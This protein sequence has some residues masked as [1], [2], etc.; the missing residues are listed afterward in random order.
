[1]L[2]LLLELVLLCFAGCGRRRSGQ[3]QAVQICV[4]SDVQV[5]LAE[6]LELRL[7]RKLVRAEL[8]LLLLL[9]HHRLLL[10]AV[11]CAGRV[12][13]RVRNE[14][15]HSAAAARRV[16]QLVLA[17]TNLQVVQLLLL[18]LQVAH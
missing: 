9:L 16:L 18:L 8:L 17:C 2:L 10:R 13:V 15:A 7:V 4:R 1:M 3:V 11:A 6:L 5:L 14:S 12:R